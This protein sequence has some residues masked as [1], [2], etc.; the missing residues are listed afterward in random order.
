MDNTQ[1]RLRR[2]LR[3]VVKKVFPLALVQVDTPFY[4]GE[5]QSCVVDKPVC[6]LI[7]GNSSGVLDG[8]KLLVSPAVGPSVGL[9]TTRARKIADTRP[10]KPLVTPKPPELNVDHHKRVKLQ[11][12]E[13]AF[14]PLF[15]DA[16]SGIVHYKL[17]GSF[18]FRIVNGL[19]YRIFVNASGET[20][21]LF[22]AV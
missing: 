18:C 17:K 14:W 4:K 2:V 9:V 15:A 13:A 16:E 6:D 5:V 10:T 20:S 8:P 11:A 22:Q 19:L 3:L 1:V 12:E 7:L 21:C